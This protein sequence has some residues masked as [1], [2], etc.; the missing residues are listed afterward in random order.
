MEDHTQLY[1]GT[2]ESDISYQPF[3]IFGYYSM[4]IKVMLILT[5][6]IGN[7]L[8]ITCILK[9]DFLRTNKN[10]LIASLS[11]SDL[12]VG[13]GIICSQMYML[14]IN[15]KC[16]SMPVRFLSYDVPLQ[17]PPMVSMCNLLCIGL[18]KFIA[19][20]F[21]LRYNALF[22][23]KTLVGIVVLAWMGP[24]LF[25]FGVLC[26][27]LSS[28]VTDC[29]NSLLS[30]DGI[31][32][33]SVCVYFI[34]AV[35]LCCM[36][37]K[38]WY[39]SRKQVQ[40]ISI[41]NASSSSKDKVSNIKATKCILMVLGAFLTSYFPSMLF[42]ISLVSNY[43][44]NATQFGQYVFTMI[45]VDGVLFNSCVNVFIYAIYSA[46]L[47]KAYKKLCCCCAKSHGHIDNVSS[48]W[49]KEQNVTVTTTP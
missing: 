7:S 43:S 40:R 36:Y 4:T 20:V 37:G 49:G 3:V 22:T 9:F 46:D 34:A 19:V 30:Q 47:R 14:A 29:E 21:P 39:D 48:S 15:G 38:I 5:I 27:A 31:M 8:T 28:R 13:L 25:S 1:N 16:I 24:V 2:T 18:D 44:A 42:C 6:I 32:I 10:I 45:M 17:V 23:K 26:T 12:A 33:T 35:L 41:M 11:C